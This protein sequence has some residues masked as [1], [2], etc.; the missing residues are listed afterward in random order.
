MVV[1]W[2][3]ETCAL[4][5]ARGTQTQGDACSCAGRQGF[6][7]SSLSKTHQGR[8]GPEGSGKHCC[9]PMGPCGAGTQHLPSAGSLW[10]GAVTCVAG[11]AM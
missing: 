3:C 10:A 9:P 6:S 8:A 4:S 1:S 11:G 5:L 2:V 7:E